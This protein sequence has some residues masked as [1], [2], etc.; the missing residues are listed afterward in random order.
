MRGTCHGKNDWE[1]IIRCMSKAILTKEFMNSLGL[2]MPIKNRVNEGGVKLHDNDIV[3][4]CDNVKCSSCINIVQVIA[5]FSEFNEE[6]N[7][8][9]MAR[10][11]AYEHSCYNKD[12]IKQDEKTMSETQPGVIEISN[13]SVLEGS[14]DG[15][16]EILG[17]RTD[18]AP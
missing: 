17:F 7:C 5:F 10:L 13:N 18:F 2:S 14:S 12:E 1:H 6:K 11:I 16:M 3:C 8:S 4:I 15:S 9:I